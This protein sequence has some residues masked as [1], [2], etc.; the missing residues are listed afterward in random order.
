M[1][2]NPTTSEECVLLIWEIQSIEVNEFQ[3]NDNSW[4]T[5]KNIQGLVLLLNLGIWERGNKSH[6]LIRK[7]PTTSF[8]FSYLQLNI[9]LSKLC[10]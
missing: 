10:R 3:W 6:T 5:I 9:V 8:Y 2:N 7:T 4:I 1:Y